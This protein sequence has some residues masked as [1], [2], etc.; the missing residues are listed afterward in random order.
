MD[1]VEFERL[2]GAAKLGKRLPTALYIH[3]DA[4]SELGEQLSDFVT[5]ISLAV[6]CDDWT[7]LK[8]FSR[9]LRL[10]FLSYPD[11]YEDSYP[12]LRKSHVDLVAKKTEKRTCS[13]QENPPILHRK[14]LLV[15][16]THPCYANSP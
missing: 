15:S 13:E 6:G 16:D 1:K 11:F 7:I 3:R 14:E 2:V 9:E 12:A 10:S 8:L 4:V 5:K